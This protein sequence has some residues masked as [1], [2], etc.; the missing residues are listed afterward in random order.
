M[1]IVY[2]GKWYIT[3][4]YNHIQYTGANGVTTEEKTWTEKEVILE[5]EYLRYYTLMNEVPFVTFTAHYPQIVNSILGSGGSGSVTGVPAGLY[6]MSIF[7]N[8]SAQP[9]ADY[10]DP[11]AGM[12]TGELIS[13]Y[14]NGRL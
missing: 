10:I 11:Y 7:Y 5:I 12:Y 4:G 9:Y 14:F 2:E 6:G 8:A 1:D 3:S 13:S